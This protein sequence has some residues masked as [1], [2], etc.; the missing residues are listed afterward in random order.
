MAGGLNTC[1]VRLRYLGLLNLEK[2][3]QEGLA[4]FQ[5]LGGGYQEDRTR[6]L[7][8]V[9]GGEDKTQWT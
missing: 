6:F 7:A 8:M 9:N 5:C 4:S 2:R 3:F 1:C